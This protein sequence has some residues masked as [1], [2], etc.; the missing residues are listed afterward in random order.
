MFQFAYIGL[1]VF[2]TVFSVFKTGFYLLDADLQSL[3]YFL[4]KIIDF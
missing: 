2:K 1:W 3:R 4:Q